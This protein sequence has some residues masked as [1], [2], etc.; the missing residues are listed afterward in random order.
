MRASNNVVDD[1]VLNVL[2]RKQE[3]IRR[4]L[5]VYLPIAD[6]DASVMEDLV[7]RIIDSKKNISQPT[8]FDDADF[9]FNDT[10]RDNRIKVFAE[11]EKMSRTY[12]AHN[13]KQMDPT[14]LTSVLN[15]AK[16]VIG[17]VEDTCDF[18][19]NQLY[20]VGVNVQKEANLCF[21]FNKADLPSNLVHYFNGCGQQVKLSFA[22]PTPKGYIYIGR[23]HTFVDDLSRGVVNDS[24]NGGSLAA[25]RAMVM[26]TKDVTTKTTILLM[27]VRSVIRDKKIKSRELVGEEMIFIGYR[28][29]IENHDFLP[30]DE[31]RELFLNAQASSNT[32]MLS[33]KQIF[34]RSIDWIYD[35]E[36]L[37]KHT[38]DIAAERANNL[39]NAFTQYR[40]YVSANE[41]QV[42]EPILPMDVIAAYVFIPKM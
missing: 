9:E 36:T 41:Y 20:N 42:V 40:N 19:V 14:R 37:R 4:Q 31:C 5:G 11:N 33:Q 29:N 38:D 22:S 34:S 27:R 8:L 16:A 17:G 13:N 15:E 28:G 39:V 24:I 35:L 2:Y 23:N 12:F 3:E 6:N 25:S 32:D 21:S 1:I 18:V 26:T 7:K 10:E 30:Q